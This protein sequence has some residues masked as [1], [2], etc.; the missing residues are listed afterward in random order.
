MTEHDIAKECEH[1]AHIAQV[2][3]YL[4]KYMEE[5]PCSYPPNIIAYNTILF[6]IIPNIHTKCP[7]D[8][9]CVVTAGQPC[10]GLL[11]AMETLD[12]AL[13]CDDLELDYELPAFVYPADYQI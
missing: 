12:E 8:D 2:I 4:K 13:E 10:G 11:D 5:N 3:L 6:G 9:D 7:H 1:L